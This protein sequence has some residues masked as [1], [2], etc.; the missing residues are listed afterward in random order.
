MITYEM[1]SAL[2]PDTWDSVYNLFGDP[3]PV[4][5]LPSG[6]FPS[7]QIF[8]PI[9]S[10][11]VQPAI[12]L[13]VPRLTSS[14]APSL[15]ETATWFSNNWIGSPYEAELARPAPFVGPPAPVS[16][17]PGI[18]GRAGSFLGDVF[19]TMAEPWERTLGG[20]VD[21]AKETFVDANK[22][23]PNLLLQRLGIIPETRVVN[24]AG[25]T[26]THVAPTPPRPLAT[27][28]G[29]K[30]EQPQYLFNLGYEGQETATV[31]PI[32][33]PSTLAALTISPVMILLGLFLFAR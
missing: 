32:A 20:M 2:M 16:T 14:D 19:D 7:P 30:Q 11:I 17:E 29:L 4:S 15:A 25:A 10:E 23:L 8:E 24:S 28:P 26:E 3:F 5:T 22:Q 27:I 1:N 33:K 21:T 31:V 6:F 18:F 9:R 13:G 12:S